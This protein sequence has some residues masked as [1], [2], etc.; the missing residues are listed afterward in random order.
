[1]NV[2]GES[3]NFSIFQ[4]FLCIS[5][6]SLVAAKGKIS[7]RNH[8]PIRYATSSYFRSFTK[9]K[10][11]KNEPPRK[12]S[13]KFAKEALVIAN[14]NINPTQHDKLTTNYFA[15]VKDRASNVEPNH[16]HDEIKSTLQRVFFM[17]S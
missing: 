5:M 7:L 9:K 12:N 14:L 10:I 3:M 11:L 17:V 16:V 8:S 2:W 6:L 13:T 4:L 15:A 1:M